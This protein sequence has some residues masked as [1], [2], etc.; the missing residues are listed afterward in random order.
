[1]WLALVL[2][3]KSS[4]VTVLPPGSTLFLTLQTVPCSQRKSHLLD[5]IHKAL[6]DLIP[7]TDF[8]S[9]SVFSEHTEFLVFFKSHDFFP[10]S[11]IQQVPYPLCLVRA[12]YPDGPSSDRPIFTNDSL[13][14]LSPLWSHVLLQNLP[15]AL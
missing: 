6:Y 4:S 9:W 3:G 15:H 11:Y 14:L 12:H 1:M 8:I 13:L 2:T 5:T 7:T 10:K